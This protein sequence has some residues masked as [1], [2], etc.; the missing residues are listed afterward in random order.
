MLLA[1][2]RRLLTVVFYTIVVSIITGLQKSDGIPTNSLIKFVLF[3]T[4][5]IKI[6]KMMYAPPLRELLV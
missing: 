4:L 2:D 1:I 3:M 5:K 6:E